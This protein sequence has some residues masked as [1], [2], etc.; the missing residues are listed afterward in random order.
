MRQDQSFSPS[1]GVT[2]PGP[3][4]LLHLLILLFLPILIRLIHLFQTILY[5]LSAGQLLKL[6]VSLIEAEQGH[7]LG[8]DELAA[9]NQLLFT[10]I[11]HDK[12]QSL[13]SPPHIQHKEFTLLIL[14]GILV[15][16]DLMASVVDLLQL[17][18]PPR[19]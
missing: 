15:L 17:R 11:L 19:F 9:S 13:S 3:L 1:E 6:E 7:R 14:M 5:I 2:P 12:Y 18:I 10:L 8:L 4:Q 16:K